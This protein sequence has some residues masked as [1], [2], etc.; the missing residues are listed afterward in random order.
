MQFPIGVFGVAISSAAA[1][2][3]ARATAGL[4]PDMAGLRRTIR[5]GLALSALLCIPAA[6]G[7]YVLGEPVVGLIYEHGRFGADDTAATAAALAA[8]AVGLAGYA[9]IKV[10]Q[11]AL[12]ALNDART[13]MF[14]ALGSIGVN[15]AANHVMVRELGWGHVGLAMST[16]CV[17]LVNALVLAAVLRKRAGGIEGRALLSSLLRIAVAA[18]VMGLVVYQVSAACQQ[19]LP[20]RGLMPRLLQTGAGVAAG[21][22]VFGALAVALGVPEVR[23]VMEMVKRRLGRA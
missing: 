16:S 19:L 20:G 3:F 12:L 7:L 14:V 22:A 23:R 15:L 18:A 8:Y 9:A 5:Q 13:P 11:P 21:A 2:E 1:P 17:A 4:S 6:V 10:L